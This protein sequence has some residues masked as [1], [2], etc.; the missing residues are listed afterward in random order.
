M[1]TPERVESYKKLA[2]RSVAARAK[3]PLA[4]G[5]ACVQLS[6]HDVLDLIHAFEELQRMTAEQVQTGAE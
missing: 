2:L 3:N 6:P 1:I 4:P 5:I